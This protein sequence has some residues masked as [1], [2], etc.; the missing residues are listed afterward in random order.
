LSPGLV[1]VLTKLFVL[2]INIFG[3]QLTS[4]EKCSKFRRS[5]GNALMNLVYQQREAKSRLCTNRQFLL[6]VAD[7]ID[8]VSPLIQ[9]VFFA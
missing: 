3:I 9:V 6:K 4:Y 1:E 8:H 2:D 7:V 5:I